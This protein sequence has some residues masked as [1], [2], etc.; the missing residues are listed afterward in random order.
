MRGDVPDAV[1]VAVS[2]LDQL[3]V[4]A[5]PPIGLLSDDDE[6]IAAHLLGDS[7][8]P[9][10]AQPKRRGRP[11]TRPVSYTHLTLPTILLV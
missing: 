2:D 3:A 1:G 6:M 5:G 11:R 7:A 9:A 4:D 10:A 8:A